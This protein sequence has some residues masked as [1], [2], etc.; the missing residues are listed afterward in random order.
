MRAK[1]I[2]T[3][4]MFEH[5]LRVRMKAETSETNSAPA[6]PGKTPDVVSLAEPT[7]VEHPALASAEVEAGEEAVLRESD[8]LQPA[9][10]KQEGSKQESSGGASNLVGRI[11]NLVTTDMQTID[12]GRDFIFVCKSPLRRRVRTWKADCDVRE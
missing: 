2:I 6:T 4:L 3:Q 11:N 9:A 5:A 10:A 12:N 1:A 7:T 8:T